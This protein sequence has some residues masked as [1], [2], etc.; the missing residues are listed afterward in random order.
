MQDCQVASSDA[1]LHTLEA[2]GYLYDGQ[3]ARGV[4]LGETAAADPH[5]HQTPAGR[6]LR[7]CGCSVLEKKVKEFR[8]PER[9][10]Y[11]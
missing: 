7:N 2:T 4:S 1:L 6:A 5:S 3:P 9:V 11:H 8:V 10:A